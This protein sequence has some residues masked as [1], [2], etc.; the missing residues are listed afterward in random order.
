MPESNRGN[1]TIHHHRGTYGMRSRQVWGE[2]HSESGQGKQG[3]QDAA[4]YPIL[5]HIAEDTE[6]SP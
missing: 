2:D 6:P 4:Y 3:E 5:D 1:Q